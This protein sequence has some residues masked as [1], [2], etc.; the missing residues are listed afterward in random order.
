MAANYMHKMLMKLTHV[1][2]FITFY[3]HYSW[4]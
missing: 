2:D 3:A 1:V 4:P